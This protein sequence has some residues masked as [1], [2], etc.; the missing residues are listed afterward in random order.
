MKGMTIDQSTMGWDIMPLAQLSES[1]R[2][3]V[4]TISARYTTP[5][6]RVGLDNLYGSEGVIEVVSTGDNARAGMGRE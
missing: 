6:H 4:S 5:E 2:G 3:D 1:T